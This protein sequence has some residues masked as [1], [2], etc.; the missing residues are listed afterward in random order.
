MFR[1]EDSPAI[2][3]TEIINLLKWKVLASLVEI[4]LSWFL[5]LDFSFLGEGGW[6]MQVELP[7]KKGKWQREFQALRISQQP[8]RRLVSS[9]PSSATVTLGSTF[10][11]SV[12]PFPRKSFLCLAYADCKLFGAVTVSHYISVQYITCWGPPILSWGQW[13]LL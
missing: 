9:N 3:G 7:L 13:E 1:L 6:I 8:V 5:H 10:H 11:L 2:K 12:P 4:K